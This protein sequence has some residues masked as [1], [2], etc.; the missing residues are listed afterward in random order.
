MSDYQTI[1][2]QV[3]NSVATITLNR[4]DKL[5]AFTD[6]MIGEVTQALKA[7]G[8]DDEVRAIL[9]TGAGRAFCAGQ[10]ISNFSGTVGEN[11]IYHHLMEH[12]RPM[13][14]LFQTTEKPILAA[15]NGAAA[16]AG[17]SLA[18]ACDLRIMSTETYLLQAFNNIGLVPDTGSTWFLVQQVGYCRAFELAVEAE[19]IPAERCLE[20]GLVNRLAEPEVLLDEARAWAEKL[21]QRPYSAG[22]TKRALLRAMTSTLLEAI[23][24]E[25]HLQQ[26]AAESEDFAEGT[27]AFREKRPPLFKGK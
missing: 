22:L 12:Y 11:R 25:A 1:L 13:I 27:A 21:A 2:Y 3:N 19:R 6:E 8:K 20:L 24:Y 5:N 17:A 9:V 15:I 18:L 7:A 14:K 23:E 16:G 4:P 10:D 26:M